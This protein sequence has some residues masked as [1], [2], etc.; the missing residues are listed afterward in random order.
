MSFDAP[1]PCFLNTSR[2]VDPI[3]SL[4]SLRQC[5]TTVPNLNLVCLEAIR[6]SSYHCYLAEEADPTLPQSPRREQFLWVRNLLW[7]A[8]IHN[9]T[10]CE[11]M[12]NYSGNLW[13]FPEADLQP[14]DQ[15][16]AFV[17]LC[18]YLAILTASLIWTNLLNKA[19]LAII[20]DSL[21]WKPAGKINWMRSI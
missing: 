15:R 13:E 20:N 19:P 21:H 17:C 18:D 6:L 3:T 4:G 12:R 14:G 5:I 11:V 7:S 10:E 8:L 1:P 9:V 16:T 2:D